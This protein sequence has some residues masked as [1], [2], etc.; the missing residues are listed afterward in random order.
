MSTEWSARL[1]AR[2]KGGTVAT[3]AEQGTR[4]ASPARPLPAVTAKGDPAVELAP[5]WVSPPGVL[6]E[7]ELD[8]CPTCRGMWLDWS[9]LEQLVD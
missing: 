3:T 9:E 1:S 2:A 5:R 8:V 6:G 4:A 7:V